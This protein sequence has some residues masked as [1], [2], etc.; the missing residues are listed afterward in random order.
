MAWA[1]QKLQD[2]KAQGKQ[3][4]AMMHHGV[5]LHF[6]GEEELFPDFLVD[7]WREVSALLADSGLRVVFTGHY[8]SQDAA[9]PLDE[10][11]KPVETLCDVETGSLVVSPCAFR[12]ATLSAGGALDIQGLQ[13]TEINADTH[14]LALQDYADAFLRERLPDI[15]TARLSGMFNL[16]PSAVAPVS[17]LVA[18]AIIANYVGDEMP[19]AQTQAVLNGLVASP[20][21]MHTLGLML[22]GFWL[23]LPPHDNQLSLQL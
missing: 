15:I 21:P 19:S 13:V 11:G 18:D 16:P 8:H 14:G 5:N 20:G 6:Q 7:D 23:D 9:F 17:P 3:V 2:A 4:I 10:Q 22:W 1:L 12:V